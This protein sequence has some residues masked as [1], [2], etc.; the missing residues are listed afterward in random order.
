MTIRETESGA[1]H[2]AIWE[3]ARRLGLYGLVD[4]ELQALI[5]QR[6]GG[7][8]PEDEVAA[9]AAQHVRRLRSKL[10]KGEAC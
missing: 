2:Q 5:Q 9:E 7:S 1:N 4:A 6:G 3:A 8:R 10:A